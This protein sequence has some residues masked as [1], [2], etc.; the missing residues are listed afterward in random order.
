MTE[1]S[2]CR[3]KSSAS[4]RWCEVRCLTRRRMGSGG[5]GWSFRK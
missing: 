4:R 5:S 3:I 2:N 1:N